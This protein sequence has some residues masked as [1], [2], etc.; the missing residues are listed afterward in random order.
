MP[1]PLLSDLRTDE[2]AFASHRQDGTPPPYEAVPYG[3]GDAALPEA[4]GHRDDC[5][6]LPQGDGLPPL[7]SF[8]DIAEC[9]PPR[10]FL[11]E[12]LLHKG[13]KMLI[14]SRSKAGKSMLLIQ[15]ALAVAGGGEWLGHRCRKGRV[16]FVNLELNEVELARRIFRVLDAGGQGHPGDGLHLWN[17]RGEGIRPLAA[18]TE[19]AIGRVEGAG[20]DLV[21]LDPFYKLA[22]GVENAA[23]D[24]AGALLRIDAIA[25]A[26]G[27]S[28]AYAHHHAKG[29]QAS[30]SVLDRASGS[31]VFARDADVLLD[32]IELSPGAARSERLSWLSGGLPPGEAAALAQEAAHWSAWRLQGISRNLPPLPARNIWFC[33]PLHTA[34]SGGFLDGARAMAPGGDEDAGDNKYEARRRENGARVVAAY[35]GHVGRTGKDP[36]AYDLADA[37]G[38]PRRTVQDHLRKAGFEPYKE[39]GEVAFRYR[40]G[41]NNG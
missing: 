39:Q 31:G 35:D 27:A 1:S 37:L 32:L 30:R 23:E 4:E 36:T 9:P 8:A 7:L 13:D 10:P 11:I 22:D 29:A 3:D 16:L 12:G 14:A 20:F 38:M 2:D 25:E 28:V 19:K 15:L 33:Y 41:E 34:D 24:V 26:S 5:P 6:V 40:F 18:F 21:V 17:L